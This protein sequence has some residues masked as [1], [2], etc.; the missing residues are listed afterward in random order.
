MVSTTILKIVSIFQGLSDQDLQKIL[1]ICEQVDIPQGSTIFEEHSINNEMYIVLEGEV[2]IRMWVP[3]E[4]KEVVL[5]TIKKGH[6]FGELSLVDDEPRS[7]T[8]IASQDVT[9]LSITRER[10]FHL[11]EQ[12]PELGITVM[13]NL[14]KILTER[15]R[16]TD[17]KWRHSVFWGGI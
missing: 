4:S 16:H 1:D 8:A 17:A 10:F 5:S 15:L 9:L 6:L 12:H 3:D 13:S 2:T 11:V 7:A 14:L